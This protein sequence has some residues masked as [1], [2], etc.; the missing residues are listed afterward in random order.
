MQI[1]GVEVY[2][3]LVVRTE[4]RRIVGAKDVQ[5]VERLRGEQGRPIAAGTPQQSRD[6]LAATA[7]GLLD[8]EDM[9]TEGRR[10]SVH[11]RA[12]LQSFATHGGTLRTI[13][14][15]IILITNSVSYV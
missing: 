14:F 4:N 7:S 2:G 9:R 3:A 10:R 13:L 1:G 6:E 12:I 15:P 11:R 5:N 8:A